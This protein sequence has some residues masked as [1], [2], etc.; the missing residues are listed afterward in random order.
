MFQRHVA[1]SN[2]PSTSI[3]RNNDFLSLKSSTA[4]SS[5]TLKSKLIDFKVLLGDQSMQ[6]QLSNTSNVVFIF[7]HVLS[8][9]LVTSFLKWVERQRH[10]FCLIQSGF[11]I[12]KELTIPPFRYLFASRSF[13]K[14]NK[15][16]S[17]DIVTPNGQSSFR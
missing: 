7:N 9:F 4:A 5:P 14:L 8:L 6:I 12:R 2:G 16:K 1:K 15:M 11:I 17:S 3:F 10:A 13:S